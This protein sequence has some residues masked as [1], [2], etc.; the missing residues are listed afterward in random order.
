MASGGE[1]RENLCE[2]SDM[3]ISCFKDHIS[4][5]FFKEDLSEDKHVQHLLVVVSTEAQTIFNQTHIRE[6]DF[7]SFSCLT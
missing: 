2:V 1:E 5:L 6:C 3:L 7:I 4:A